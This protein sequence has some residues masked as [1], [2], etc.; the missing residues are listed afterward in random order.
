MVLTEGWKRKIIFEDIPLWCDI[1]TFPCMKILSEKS[2]L[3]AVH[4]NEVEILWKTV[5]TIWYLRDSGI[6]PHHLNL[7]Y[8]TVFILLVTG[9]N[10]DIS[11]FL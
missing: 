10:M 7:N 1:F 11:Y 8:F 6:P 9:I 2:L 3:T 4:G 5:T